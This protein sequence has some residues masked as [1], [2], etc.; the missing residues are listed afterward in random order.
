MMILDIQN[1]QFK[2]DHFVFKIFDN[3][4]ADMINLCKYVQ[5]VSYKHYCKSSRNQIKIGSKVT[6]EDM[7][8]VESH[9]ERN[10]NRLHD[11]YLFFKQ[12]S[13]FKFIKFHKLQS[14]HKKIIT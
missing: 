1:N 12:Y 10:A 6:G 2:T 11:A 9:K 8:Y 7:F 3:Q 13:R 4:D 5:C 14:T